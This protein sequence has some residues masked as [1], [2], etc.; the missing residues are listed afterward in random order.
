M[1]EM[2]CDYW[3]SSILGL[4]SNEE[5]S[6]RCLHRENTQVVL[7]ART[8]GCRS[9]LLLVREGACASVVRCR[10]AS[11]IGRDE[12]HSPTYKQESHTTDSCGKRN[13]CRV[14]G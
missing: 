4:I 11:R 1:A 13:S 14:V 8:S 2:R 10:H 5:Q 6:R 12:F 3:E 9:G 7:G